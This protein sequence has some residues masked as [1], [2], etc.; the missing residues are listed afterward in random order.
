MRQI[1]LIFLLTLGLYAKTIT[2]NEVYAQAILISQ[3]THSLLK[4]YDVKHDHNGIIRH[5]TIKTQLKPRNVWQMTYEI[6]IKINIFRVTHN[7]PIIEP[8][9]MPP[10]LNL[11]PSLVYEQTQ[12]ILTEI[13]I[14]KY[15]MGIKD[16]GLKANVYTNKT[17]LDVFNILLQ[18]SASFDELNQAKFSPSYVFGETMRVYDDLTAILSFLKIKDYTTPTSRNKDATPKDTFKVAMNILTIIKQIQFSVGIRR[19]DFSV[20]KKENLIPS[21][22]FTLNQMII[23]EIQTIKAYIGLKSFITPAAR[24]FTDKT[25]ADVEQLMNWNL[26]KISLINISAGI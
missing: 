26:R 1:V 18:I 17:P 6:S 12:R 25:P 14:F 2:P 10:M 9:N 15:R 13:R 24:N 5:K 22:V 23:S 7:L 3:E 16:S 19:V 8:I 4:Y 21:D 20:F 11:N